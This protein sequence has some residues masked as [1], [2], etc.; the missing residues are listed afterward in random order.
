MVDHATSGKRCDCRRAVLWLG[1]QGVR[2]SAAF[3]LRCRCLRARSGPADGWC[4]GGVPLPIPIPAVPQRTSNGTNAPED[5]TKASEPVANENGHFGDDETGVT[6][7]LARPGNRATTFHR[8]DHLGRNY[9]RHD[10]LGTGARS[11]RAS[12]RPPYLDPTTGPPPS[13]GAIS[14]QPEESNWRPRTARRD[15]KTRASSPR[16]R[17][18]GVS[19]D[20]IAPVPDSVPT[21]AAGAGWRRFPMRWRRPPRRWRRFL[22]SARW[23]RTCS[24]RCRCGR[25]GHAT[26]GRPL[27]LLGGHRR[28]GANGGGL[29]SSR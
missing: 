3:A 6:S 5:G 28:G 17:A 29:M 2:G 27:F 9:L 12:S 15:R 10:H 18:G 11:T 19:Y 26:A 16:F 23:F 14:P 25:P 24:P 4:R 22:T 13:T 20:A 1:G 21:P 7:T 8:H